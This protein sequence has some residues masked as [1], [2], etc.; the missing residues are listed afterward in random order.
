MSRQ[1]L[2]DASDDEKNK[3]SSEPTA[4]MVAI[5]LPG[6]PLQKKRAS[7]IGESDDEQ[8]ILKTESDE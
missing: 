8:S 4:R 6:I 5:L 1:Q 7:G 3:T 2:R